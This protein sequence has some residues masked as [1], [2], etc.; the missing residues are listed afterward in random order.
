MLERLQSGDRRVGVKQSTK[1]VKEGRATVA[2]VA[3]DADP[4]LTEPFLALCTAHN[5]EIVLIPTMREL[6]ASCGV[7]VGSAVAVGLK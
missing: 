1:A 7:A 3:K 2:F 5:V 6:G 4:R